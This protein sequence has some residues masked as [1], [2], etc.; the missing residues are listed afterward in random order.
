MFVC[1]FVISQECEFRTGG[2]QYNHIYSNRRSS[3]RSF[4]EV[5]A[6]PEGLLQGLFAA[7]RARWMMMEAMVDVITARFDP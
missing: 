1:L 4:H 3:L 5:E 2:P 7:Q 6:G